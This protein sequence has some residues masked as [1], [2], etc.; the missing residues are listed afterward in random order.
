MSKP[1]VKPPV[2]TSVSGGGTSCFGLPFERLSNRFTFEWTNFSLLKK[3]GMESWWTAP[4]PSD[5]PDPG[6]IRDSLDEAGITEQIVEG[7]VDAIR[8]VEGKRPQCVSARSRKKGIE[9]IANLHAQICDDRFKS[10][11]L[12]LP[13]STPE[14]RCT[15]PCTHVDLTYSALNPIA[16]SEAGFTRACGMTQLQHIAW[17]QAVAE[18]GGMVAH[19]Y[20]VNGI[21]F[22]QPNIVPLLVQ[23]INAHDWT[24]LPFAVLSNHAH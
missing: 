15:L 17:E 13:K 24:E 12:L 9:R 1:E 10:S 2:D 21:T 23:K 14:G 8:C 20:Q 16:S 7:E 19:T 18:S 6:T 3:L 5:F 22:R 11:N 4:S